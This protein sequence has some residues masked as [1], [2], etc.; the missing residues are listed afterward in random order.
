MAVGGMLAFDNGLFKEK[1]A[2]TLAGWTGIG[3]IMISYFVFD[4][5]STWPGWCA[6]VPCAGAVLFI[7]S[8][9]VERNSAGALLASKPLVF[10]GK[11]SYSLYLWHWPIFVYCSQTTPGTLTPLQRTLGITASLAIAVLSFYLVE[12]MTRSSHKVSDR[13]F[14]ATSACGWGGLLA[15][16]LVATDRDVGGLH[17]ETTSVQLVDSCQA[18]CNTTSCAT[19]EKCADSAWPKPGSAVSRAVNDTC[20]AC[21]GCEVFLTQSNIE[22]VHAVNSTSIQLG[23]LMSTVAW[24]SQRFDTALDAPYVTNGGTTPS[25]AFIGSS[26][27]EYLARYLCQ[28]LLL[29]MRSCC[30]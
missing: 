2:A 7:M 6:M 14:Y 16:C 11:I 26:H 3:M 21:T 9:R 22:R 30:A 27:C 10:V 20:T 25:I 28:L 23:Q 17:F 8:Q 5:T 15:F 19:L 12:S 18:R 4:S 1:V 13:V 29:I 24:A